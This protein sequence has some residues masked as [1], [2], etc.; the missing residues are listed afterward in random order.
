MPLEHAEE[1]VMIAVR[2][3][4][5]IYIHIDENECKPLSYKFQMT[6]RLKC[7]E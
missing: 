7:K 5:L 3:A 1:K 2:G 6:P 4:E